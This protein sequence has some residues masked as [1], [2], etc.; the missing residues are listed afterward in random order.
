MKTL[1]AGSYEDFYWSQRDWELIFD[2]SRIVNVTKASLRTSPKTLFTKV[3]QVLDT[4]VCFVG[5]YILIKNTIS[6]EQPLVSKQHKL[7]WCYSTCVS[8]LVRTWK[9]TVSGD[10]SFSG[11]EHFP[12]I[13]IFWFKQAKEMSKVGKNQVISSYNIISREITD[14]SNSS[15]IWFQRPFEIRSK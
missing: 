4:W 10:M 2:H 7:N 6:F 5:T 11:Q 8:Y 9:I 3:V 1:I 15:I 13:E 14:C 12:A